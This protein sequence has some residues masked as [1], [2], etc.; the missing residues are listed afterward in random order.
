MNNWFSVG[1]EVLVQSKNYPHINGEYTIAEILTN[2]QACQRIGYDKLPTF[3][4]TAYFV[5]QG[6]NFS[7]KL[8]LGINFDFVCYTAVRKKHRLSSEDFQSMMDTLK[9][10]IVETV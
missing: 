1:E 2:S 4:S 3:I 10:N 8:G 9:T 7:D 5:M 6:L